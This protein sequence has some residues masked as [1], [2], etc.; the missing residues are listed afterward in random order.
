M[1]QSLWIRPRR[2]Y[3]ILYFFTDQYTS[4]PP[5]VYFGV[6]IAIIVSI[7]NEGPR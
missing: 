7:S 4:I 1:F 5:V 6:G 3:V 2:T